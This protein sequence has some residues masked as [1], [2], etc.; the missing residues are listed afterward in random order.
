MSAA[1]MAPTNPLWLALS[2]FHPPD[3]SIAV[4]FQVAASKALQQEIGYSVDPH[5]SILPVHEIASA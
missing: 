1:L 5:Q 3:I 4:D 2:S